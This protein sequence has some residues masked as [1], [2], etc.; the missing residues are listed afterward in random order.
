MGQGLQQAE[1]GVK[2]LNEY[3]RK[4]DKNGEYVADFWELM[5]DANTYTPSAG[6]HEKYYDQRTGTILKYIPYAQS[7]VATFRSSSKST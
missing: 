6:L 3:G 5:Y 7:V 1:A 4:K 2:Y